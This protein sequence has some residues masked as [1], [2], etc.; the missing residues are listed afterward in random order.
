MKSRRSFIH[1]SML[2][3]ASGAIGLPELAAAT[4]TKPV[5][6]L[7][8]LKGRKILFTYGGWK[9]HEPEKWKDYLVPWL[10]EEGASVE[11]SEMLEPY[12]DESF[13]A[14]IDLVVQ[15]HT[16]SKISKE[17]EKGLLN[18]IKKGTGMTGWHGGMCDSFRQSVAYQY[19][20]GGQWVAHPGNIIDYS[21]QVIDHNDP[22][23]AGLSSSFDVKTEQYYMHVDPNVKVLATTQFSGEHDDWIDGSIMPVVWKKMYGKGRVFFTSLGHN[24]S[25]VTEVPDALAIALRGIKW[26]SASKYLPK[27]EWVS[28]VYK[29]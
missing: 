6:D 10:E 21:V 9:G 27:E 26:A 12:A 16:M 11:T 24:L 3:A 17:E 13:M 4:G 8:S 19:M 14:G 20:T 1:K 5:Q 29:S 23:T 15:V 7:P 22:V 2:L 28:P 25:H 18:A